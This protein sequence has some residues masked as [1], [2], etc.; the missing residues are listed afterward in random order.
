M[1]KKVYDLGAAGNGFEEYQWNK[2][3]V[4]NYVFLNVKNKKCHIRMAT[5]I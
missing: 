4:N 5:K 3:F 1:D 2:N